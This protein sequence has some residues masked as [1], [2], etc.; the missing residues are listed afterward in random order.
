MIKLF[1]CDCLDFLCSQNCED[2]LKGRKAVIVTNPP[3]NIGYHYNQYKDNI[4]EGKYFECLKNILTRRGLPFVVIHLQPYKNPNDKRIKKRIKNGKLGCKLYDWGN[5]NQVKKVSKKGLTHPC[6]MP[7]EVM[8]NIIGVL[9]EDYIIID[10]FMGSGSTGIAAK[11]LGRDFI[12]CELNEEYFNEAIERL[13][14]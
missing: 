14:E 9:P 11:Q 7:V 12:G 10:P 2:L 6:I 8:K 4:D 1:N 3:F 5:I 13:K